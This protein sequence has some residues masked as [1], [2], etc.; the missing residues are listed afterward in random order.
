MFCG[1]CGKQNPDDATLCSGCGATLT[2][3]AT[4]GKRSRRRKNNYAMVG[5]IAVAVVVVLVVV[6]LVALFSGRSAKATGVKFIEAVFDGDGEEIVDLIPDSYFKQYAREMDVKVSRVKD[7]FEESFEDQFD[8]ISEMMDD[9]KVTAKATGTDDYSKRETEDI[10]DSYEDADVKVKDARTVEVEVTLK[11]R[12]EKVELGT[13]IE[14]P[15]I[16]VGG[17]WY[18][19][20]INLG[21]MGYSVLNALGGSLG[22]FLGW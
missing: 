6:L 15:V 17:S 7:Q 16:K 4:S 20:V 14:V 9:V 10:I 22:G 11:Y 5:M 19:D 13:P 21:S 8:A 1:N 18:I 3:V 12:G 2:P